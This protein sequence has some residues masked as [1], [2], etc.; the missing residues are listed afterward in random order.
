MGYLTFK[1]PKQFD[2][3]IKVPARVLF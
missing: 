1:P 2:L 3:A